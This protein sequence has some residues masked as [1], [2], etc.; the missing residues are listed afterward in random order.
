MDNIY[1]YS[2]L[3]YSCG[4]S[5][6]TSLGPGDHPGMNIPLGLTDQGLPVGV[7]LVG[8]YWSEKEMFHFARQL[9]ELT[10]GFI[11]PDM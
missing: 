9:V 6:H 8:P 4:L 11:P 5:R 7:Q 1:L 2:L 3:W 10:P